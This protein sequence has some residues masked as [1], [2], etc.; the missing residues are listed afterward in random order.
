MRRI[1]FLKTTI[2]HGSNNLLKTYEKHFSVPNMQLKILIS[3][4]SLVL[5]GFFA[6]SELKGTLEGK[7]YSNVDM[8]FLFVLACME[9]SLINL[10][11]SG[12]YQSSHALLRHYQHSIV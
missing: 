10:S 3:Q 5:N 11:K 8:V 9:R 1:N 6:K 12:P 2:L 4:R 7:D